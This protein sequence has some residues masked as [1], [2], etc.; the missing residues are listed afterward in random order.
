MPVRSRRATPRGRKPPVSLARSKTGALCLGP[1]GPQTLAAGPGG[2]EQ[3][4]GGH[5]REGRDSL[6]QLELPEPE[7]AIWRP[8][9]EQ[10]VVRAQVPWTPHASLLSVKCPVNVSSMQQQPEPAWPVQ[11]PSGDRGNRDSA[12]CPP[13]PCLCRSGCPARG[14]PLFISMLRVACG[15]ECAPPQCARAP[16]KKALPSLFIVIK[17]P[18]HKTNPLGHFSAS[19]LWA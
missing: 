16:Q 7:P 12:I 4:L 11:A 8:R 14:A 3:L 6:K 13:L 18:S 10:P 19:S 2:A 15:I 5:L 17:Y 1:Q 9:P